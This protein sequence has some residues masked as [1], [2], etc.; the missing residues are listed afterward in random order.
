LALSYLKDI[1]K[2]HPNISK[3]KLS[4]GKK[5]L[6]H[7]LLK[8]LNGSVASLIA[9][10]IFE[11]HNQLAVIIMP[12][13]EE[14]AYFSNDMGR[15]LP[16][17]E[18]MYYPS[19]FKR[20]VK[21][22]R[23]ERS[24]IVLR[25]EVLNKIITNNKKWC[26]VTY[27]E[28]IAEKVITGETLK[29][30]ML[31]ITV[32]D[33]LSI[34]FITEVLN[35]YRFE[36][37]D[38]VYEPGQFALRGSIID[39]FSFS[40]NNPYRIDF[41]GDEI[42]SI[43][44]FDVESQVSFDKTDKITILPNIQQDNQEREIFFKLLPENTF[45]WI[46]DTSVVK[47]QIDNSYTEALNSRIDQENEDVDK[48]MANGNDVIEKLNDFP[49]I[50][51]G[52]NSRKPYANTIEFNCKP[53][54][55]FNKKFDLLGKDLKKH[56]DNGYENIILSDNLKQIDRLQAIFEEIDI[57]VC[58]KPL[59]NTLHEGFIDQDSK[60]CCY[61]DHQIFERY[62]RPA[63]KNKSARKDTITIRELHNLHP[64]DYVVHVD[65][66]IGKFGGLQKIEVNG[67]KQ[68]AI[69][70]IYK[71][72]DSLFVSIHALHKV[73]K[74]KGK[75]G[76]PPK[77]YKLGSA[78]WRN[79]K[80]R[81]KKKVKDIARELIA[82]YA[83][84]KEQKG[85]EFSPDTYLQNELEASF[86]YEDTPDQYKATNQVKE[87]ME[88]PYPMDILVCGDVGF[89][90]TE[91]AIRAAFKAVAD[92][93]QV[94]VLVPTTILALQHY[95]TFKDRLNDFPCNV[96]FIC[97]LKTTAEVKRSLQLV[98]EGKTDIIIGTHRLVSKDVSFEDLGLLI[99]DE[100]QKFGVSVKEKLKNFKL[101]V[102]TL[103]LTATPIPRTLQFSLMGARDLSII[104]TPPPNRQP[105]VSEVHP[106]N[107][108]IISEAIYYE[109]SRNGQVFFIH[110]WVHNIYEVEHL[111]KKTCPEIKTAV[112]HGQM[113]GPELE[114]IMLDFINGDYD[115]LIATTII[116]SGLDIPNV[117]T[118]IINNAHHFGV[119]D[120]HQL[121]GRV[122]RSNRKAFCYLL[123]PPVGTLSPNARRRLKAIED[124]SD[125]GSGFNIAMQDLDIRGAGNLLGSEQSGFIG[126]IGFETYHRILDEA[127][128]ELKNEE[129]SN[130]FKDTTTTQPINEI[131][132]EMI[133]IN[134]CQIDT[135]MQILIP[136]SYIT[137]VSERIRLY[138]VLDDI[139]TEEALLK[140]EHDLVDRFGPVP[141]PVQEL[142]EVVR[143]R[144]KAIKLGFEKLILKNKI[145]VAS[146]VSDQESP[147]YKSPVFSNILSYIQREK[148]KYNLK[149]K[150]GK[151]NIII[152]GI[153]HIKDANE[154][155]EKLIELNNVPA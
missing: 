71:D 125:L 67:K 85:F 59:L 100:E 150:N 22:N 91:V 134:D 2:R 63:I 113:K 148:D 86:I 121:R 18:I 74:Y 79:I 31:T 6:N 151:L 77:I 94:A 42:E 145:I 1:Y 110:N 92:N 19:S 119:S 25:S 20:S 64:G 66:G 24:N 37:V 65:H 83:K 116:E 15:L 46:K 105:I 128:Q 124:F 72:N 69:K 51:T 35:E 3:I 38:F 144:W 53:Q 139:E 54:P 30:Q 23:V 36:L 34:D 33:K 28:A 14:A 96:D 43:R 93:K 111:I 12:N 102:D 127:L 81:T 101:N 39:I 73:S 152:T 120:L 95:N 155:L 104:N 131:S 57:N 58:F 49:V 154:L 84:R 8:G 80:Q 76:E 114:N 26:I 10:A 29:E 98:E 147:Y 41:F 7:T 117:N 118:I 70:L 56:D 140:F 45:V 103:T 143:L 142:M 60:L 27:P 87:G 129:Y 4:I 99:I 122:G 11:E 133:F 5:G 82:L 141:E 138:R 55:V 106:F 44:T 130:L 123:A 112:A 90:K 21:Y 97:R 115:V 146:F 78:A 137:N 136:D 135:D 17:Q 9:A 149:E 88:K 75:E 89:G 32:Q 48:V 52:V 13:S 153:D 61:T 108:D 50:E 40:G 16:E 107:Q 47:N 132:E 126:D 109:I 68:E 62:H